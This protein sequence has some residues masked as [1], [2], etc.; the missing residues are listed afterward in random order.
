MAAPVEEFHDLFPLVLCLA[1]AVLLGHAVHCRRIAFLTEATVS[2]L[3]GLVAGGAVVAYY[4]WYR[5]GRIPA[6]L[7][8][9]N[10]EIFFDALLPPIIFNAGF[11]AKKKSFFRNFVTLA[12]FGVV[13]TFMTAA[14][15]AA[16]C[17][18]VLSY[19]GIDTHLLSD[20]LS[21]GTVFS[22]TDSVATLQILDADQAPM[23]YS[24]VFGEG[25]VND[26][27]SIVLLR[28]VQK[29]SHSSQLNADT[30]LLISGNFARLF[31]LSLLLGVGVGLASAALIKRSFAHHST[32][33]EVTLVG[34]LGF[35]AYLLAEELGLSG[36]FSVFF[37]GIAMSHY[38]WHALSP[39]AKVVT[40]YLFRIASF[41]SELFLFLYAGFSM[42]SSAL[43]RGDLGEESLLARAAGTLAAALVALVLVARALT[44]AP[45]TCVANLW[46]PPGCRISARQA[47]VIWWSGSM[48]GAITVAMAFQ[49]FS[50]SHSAGAA[51][52]KNNQKIVVASNAAVIFFT[53]VMGG[54]TSWLLRL[55]LPGEDDAM[56][57]QPSALASYAALEPT[58][59]SAPLLASALQRHLHWTKQSPIY[60]WWHRLD[61]GVLYPLFGGRAPQAAGYHS[62]PP[63][64]GRRV[65]TSVMGPSI[66]KRLTPMPQPGAPGAAARPLV[67]G[68]G[69]AAALQAQAE[70]ATAAA[71]PGGA[72]AP[73]PQTSPPPS[74]TGR[75]RHPDPFRLWPAPSEPTSEGPPGEAGAGARPAAG[76]TPLRASRA[77]SRALSRRG[78]MHPEAL[79]M[80]PSDAL[81]ELFSMPSGRLDSAASQQVD[82]SDSEEF[83]EEAA[84]LAAGAPSDEI[85][86][87]TAQ[88]QQ[89]QQQQAAPT[90][91][92]RLS[93]PSPFQRQISS[94]GKGGDPPV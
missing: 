32:D 92:P 68:A 35:L 45:L 44:V 50:N 33:R 29:I 88:Q 69:A 74:S 53:V 49:N 36:I 47:A 20:S 87:P 94:H 19:V 55:L 17:H 38:T 85:G 14:M 7:T 82:W 83:G 65:I 41:S 72:P 42:W 43:W 70:A 12:L 73:A 66:L 11:S 78:S 6:S 3:V 37:C 22:S 51:A 9:F 27:T 54:M 1:L 60:T 8:E 89:Q 75:A 24:L 76:R 91:P 26:A 10:T 59:V 77:A 34:L 52:L 13:G 21:L 46:R 79:E 67:N 16:G 5:G 2:L 23:L 86:S 61:E 30:L 39:S 31:V 84:F 63:S 64:P 90:G 28:A 4:I 15:V 57:L 48:R 62:P 18:R 56:S 58:G 80:Q 25:I 93:R 81:E 40:V 71:V